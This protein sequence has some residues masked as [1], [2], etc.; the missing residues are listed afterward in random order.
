MWMIK[1]R[2]NNIS[3]QGRDLK[4][5]GKVCWKRYHLARL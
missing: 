4:N 1:F 5:F 3:A 2:Y